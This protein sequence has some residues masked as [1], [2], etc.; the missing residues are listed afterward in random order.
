MTGFLAWDR[1][2]RSVGFGNT[3]PWW[4]LRLCAQH[5]LDVTL[6]YSKKMTVPISPTTMGPSAGENEFQTFA[7][8][9]VERSLI[10]RFEDQVRIQGDRRAVK[11]GETVL[12]YTELNQITN[13]IARTIIAKVGSGNH[14]VA[15]L[16]GQGLDFVCANWGIW[17]A[18][19]ISVPLGDGFPDSVLAK[20]IE[21]AQARLILCND[22]TVETAMRVAGSADRILNLSQT[23]DHQDSGNL[24]LDIGPD[25]LAMI[26]YTSGSTGSPKGVTHSHRSMLWTIRYA[27]NRFDVRPQDRYSLLHTPSAVSAQTTVTRAHLFGASVYPYNV[28]QN[29]SNRLGPWM[30]QEKITH[31][32]SVPTLFRLF[33]AALDGGVI[34]PDVRFVWL[35]GEAVTQNDFHLWR[36]HFSANCQLVNNLGATETMGISHCFFNRDDLTNLTDQAIL[37]LGREYDGKAI[38][39]IDEQGH[40]LPPNTIGEI[41]VTSKYISPGYWRDEELTR[42]KF[43]QGFGTADPADKDLRTYVTGDLGKLSKDGSLTHLG[44]KDEQFK[45]RGY[46]IEPAAIEQAIKNALQIDHVAVVKREAPNGQAFLVAFYVASEGS[47]G[48][49]IDPAPLQRQLAQTIPDYMVPVRFEA[50]VSFPL[51]ATG[52]IDRRALPELPALEGTSTPWRNDTQ[53]RLGEIWLDALPVTSLGANDNFFDLGGHSLAAAQMMGAIER[54]FGVRFT[55]AKLV[56]APTIA[57]L[58]DAIS[59][60]DEVAE[61]SCLVALQPDGDRPGLFL[62]PPAA[63]S[64]IRLQALALLMGP[65]QP[66]YGFEPMGM[67]GQSPAHNRIEDMAAHYIAR[68]RQ[69]QPQGPYYLGGRCVG[70]FVALEMAHQLIAQGQ[71]IGLLAVIEAGLP[72]RF[73]RRHRTLRVL[74]L[75]QQAQQAIHQVRRFL[76]HKLKGTKAP[77]DHNDRHI[78][79]WKQHGTVLSKDEIDRYRAL[80]R[81]HFRARDRYLP[82]IFPGKITLIRAADRER[83]QVEQLLGWK[84]LTDEELDVIDVPGNHRTLLQEPNVQILASEL[85]ERLK[86]LQ[87]LNSLNCRRRW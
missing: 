34:F 26:V 23:D 69:Q 24:G 75:K 48:R 3:V 49:A 41:A 84:D 14:P 76:S 80:E 39:I 12:S 67:D 8:R 45:I 20:M 44:R 53:R 5:H 64:A 10:C 27:G 68:M 55:L 59:A 77:D 72:P 42:K 79:R 57:L 56:E 51:T 11:D 36:E 17:K 86:I 15:S 52:K 31:Y 2:P 43:L 33:M 61:S 9:E 1:R 83:L 13:R 74:W 58:A 50:L 73:M 38:T 16:L 71:T 78:A 25:D 35:G 7:A 40:S 66:V 87:G 63:T 81:R 19:K 22:E 4:F 47:G 21:H 54:D 32:H 30:L 6:K 28:K 65:E 82:R 37:P 29:L 70:A 46:R 60:K 85:M 62:V 18:G